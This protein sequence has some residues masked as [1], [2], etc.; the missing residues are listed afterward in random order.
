MIGRRGTKF[1]RAYHE[2]FRQWPGVFFQFPSVFRRTSAP[3]TPFPHT[4]HLNTNIQNS[5]MAC[6]A[7]TFTGSVAALKASKVQ[8]RVARRTR[9]RAARRVSREFPANSRSASRATPRGPAPAGA[10]RN[11]RAREPTRSGMSSTRAGAD[12]LSR[13]HQAVAAEFR[14]GR[15]REISQIHRERGF[16][17]H[18]DPTGTRR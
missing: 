9:A 16:P 5:T 3:R 11:R 14:R 7:S 15:M 4:Q 12:G 18:P 2:A 17:R 8:V 1:H 13:P 10:K 6:I